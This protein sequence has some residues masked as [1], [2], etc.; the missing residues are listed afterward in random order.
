VLSY[1]AKSLQVWE[2]TD[3]A[4][5]WPGL[6]REAM[7]GQVFAFGN[8]DFL[9][10]AAVHG[11]AHLALF[12][13]KLWDRYNLAKL[14]GGKFAANSLI[15]ESAGVSPED[16]L[17]KPAGFYGPANNNILSLQRRGAVFIAC[18]DSTHAIAR[19]LHEDPAFASRSADEI[20]ADLTNGLI[21]NAVLVPSVVVFLTELE[22][23]GFTYSKGG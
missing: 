23:A 9:P 21:A 13:Q 3:L 5:P 10:V 20:A 6:M 4:G 16:D 8:R 17:Q 22:R 15:V 1:R 2:P 11:G 12:D 14:T 19:S 7:N 18:H